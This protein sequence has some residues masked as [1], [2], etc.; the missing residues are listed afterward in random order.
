MQTSRQASSPPV[1]CT[2]HRTNTAQRLAQRTQ[3]LLGKTVIIRSQQQI[4]IRQGVGRP[5]PTRSSM[6]RMHRPPSALA[7]LQ[8]L[9]IPRQAK[10][11]PGAPALPGA[12]PAGPAARPVQQAD[13]SP[14]CPLH[15]PQRAGLG[16]PSSSQR[17]LLQLGPRTTLS[18][19]EQPLQGLPTSQTRLRSP[20]GPQQGPLGLPSSPPH[21]PFPQAA[22]GSREHR[23]SPHSRPQ[24]GP[25]PMQKTPYPTAQ[26]DQILLLQLGQAHLLQHMCLA[27]PLEQE[28]Q[29]EGPSHS[30]RVRPRRLQRPLSSLLGPFP[31]AEGLSTQAVHSSSQAQAAQQLP[32]KRQLQGAVLQGE[33]GVRPH[34]L[35]SPRF[36]LLAPSASDEGTH[37][38][39]AG[40]SSHKGVPR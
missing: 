34:G 17:P 33:H 32:R 10:R 1:Y 16:S 21:P 20:F 30:T 38:L 31:S 4:G 37:G 2:S 28:L 23:L 11:A 7:R 18:T 19:V 13:C 15:R 8:Q 6:F 9:S 36:S 14:L 27:S 24:P 3:P 29:Q 22:H 12:Q 39:A 40:L 5:F 35:H 25:S 26:L